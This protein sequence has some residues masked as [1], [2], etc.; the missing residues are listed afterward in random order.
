MESHLKYSKRQGCAPVER[1][2][3]FCT[4]L[5]PDGKECRTVVGE[6]HYRFCRQHHREQI[7]MYNLYKL[8]EGEYNTICVDDSEDD[9]TRLEEKIR[10][11]EEAVELRDAV[12]RRFYSLSGDNRGHIRWI[13]KLRSEID[14]LKKASLSSGGP[15]DPSELSPAPSETNNKSEAEGGE[16]VYRSLISPE[17]PMSALDHLPRDSPAVVIKESLNMMLSS[18]VD[19][20]YEFAPSLDDSGRSVGDAS[21]AEGQGPGADGLVIRY[22]LR[23]FLVWKADT[24]TLARASQTGSIDHFLRRSTTDELEEYVK[25]FEGLG[26]PDTLHF[27]R[28]AVYDYLLPDGSPSTITI[29]G[30][31]IS[32]DTAGR[33][34]TVEGWDILYQYFWN[35]I[36]WWNLEQLCF[37]FED[38]ALVKRLVALRRYDDEEANWF[39]PEDDVSQECEMAV[40][41]GFDAL[42]KGF[43]DPPYQ[44]FVSRGGITTEKESRCYLVGRM[45]KSDPLALPF[46]KEMSTRVARFTVMSIDMESADWW[47]QSNAQEDAGG[48]PFI[49]RSRSAKNKADL[50]N[51]PWSVEWSVEDIR[52]DVRQ[53]RTMKDREAF[54]DFHLII[55]IDRLPERKF[56]ILEAAAEAL[57]E[58]AGDRTC[59]E[60][61]DRAVRESIPAPEREAWSAAVPDD[62]YSAVVEPGTAS[63]H[64]EGHRVR[65]WD[66]VEK[67]PG[68]DRDQARLPQT[69][70]EVRFIRKVLAEMESQKAITLLET[71]EAP[72]CAPMLYQSIDG[73][74][75]LFFPYRYRPS[76]DRESR[77]RNSLAAAGADASAGGLYDF[78]RSYL[79]SHPEA[80]FAKG[81]IEVHYC[82]WPLKITDHV[83]SPPSF[84]TAQGHLYRWNVI[85]FDHPRATQIWQWYLHQIFNKRM[86]FVCCLHTTFVVCAASRD[87]AADNLRVLTQEAARYD[88]KLSVKPAA[89]WRWD[90]ESLGLDR[91]WRGVPPDIR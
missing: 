38:V 10:V 15:P 50:R 27:L 14:G 53:I 34:M 77:L 12:N 46:I 37:S 82:A 55:I 80:V 67:L 81:R 25:L 18:L 91:L 26:R 41:Q 62:P 68:F 13:L 48:V 17:V 85:S 44:Q 11:G 3:P 43:S 51:T 5:L 70:A 4:A 86:P 36:G 71:F 75:D 20:L 89:L 56:T 64:Y 49:T 73:R 65:Q 52:E 33:R 47:R 57:K 83:R 39:R 61:V 9:K 76:P 8:R 19:K 32:T 30:A 42:S 2:K 58:V 63:P 66:L 88:L 90:I 21:T 54:S 24:E 40:L 35:L 23:E 6:P 16:W 74:Q 28:D 45:G 22:I 78:A 31:F 84:Q 1:R 87:E 79:R 7:R 59:R 60:I 72:V 29:L 69:Y